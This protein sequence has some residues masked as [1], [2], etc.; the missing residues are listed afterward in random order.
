MREKL[1]KEGRGG[2]IVLVGIV[3]PV[4]VEL[5]L[6]VVEFEVR[7]VRKIAIPVRLD[8]IRPSK[9]PDIEIYFPLEAELCS[10]DPEFNS[11]ASKKGTRARRMQAVSP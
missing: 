8:C 4:R 6:A 1:R 3:D 10:L 11:A 9:A 2:A 5:D 7:R